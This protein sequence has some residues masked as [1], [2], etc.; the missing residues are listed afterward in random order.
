MDSRESLV[1]DEVD[2]DDEE[3]EEEVLEVE[4]EMSFFIFRRPSS[5]SCVEAATFSDSASFASAALSSV[6]AALSL[7]M[8]SKEAFISL[9]SSNAR[10]VS[11]LQA[12]MEVIESMNP[13]RDGK[14]G[15]DGF[16]ISLKSS[17]RSSLMIESC[18]A[19]LL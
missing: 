13:T 1:L 8:R 5:D 9:I 6:L 11:F 15:I 18:A 12:E 16:F 14:F 19:I 3:D 10:S 2:E 4:D 17:A 7:M